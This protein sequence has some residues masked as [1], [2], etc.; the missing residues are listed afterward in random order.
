MVLG[1]LDQNNTPVVHIGW[2]VP[3]AKGDFV[4]SARE[5]N[6]FPRKA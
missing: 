5:G 3:T 4:S 2:Q 6:I 1:A